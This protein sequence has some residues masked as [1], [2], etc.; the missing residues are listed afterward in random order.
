MA[1]GRRQRLR[2]CCYEFFAP[3]ADRFDLLEAER[4]QLPSPRRVRSSSQPEIIGSASS[5]ALPAYSQPHPPGGPSGSPSIPPA[6]LRSPGGPPVSP[7][8]PPARS[9]RGR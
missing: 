4:A 6:R 5:L 9:V 1:A 3:P 8:V 2:S 7:V